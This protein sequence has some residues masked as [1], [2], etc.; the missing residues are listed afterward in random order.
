MICRAIDIVLLARG[1]TVV[2][3]TVLAAA[4]IGIYNLMITALP[5]SMLSGGL[6][7]CPLIAILLMET[8]HMPSCRPARWRPLLTSMDYHSF[9]RKVLRRDKRKRA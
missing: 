7:I 6:V 8:Q 9:V 1:K 2:A 5:T 4:F 3:V